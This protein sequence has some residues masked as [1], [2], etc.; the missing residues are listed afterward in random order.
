[1]FLWSHLRILNISD[2]HS[3]HLYGQTLE[4]YL[5]IATPLCAAR[6]FVLLL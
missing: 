6:F 3:L 2:D 4:F 5:P 1:M